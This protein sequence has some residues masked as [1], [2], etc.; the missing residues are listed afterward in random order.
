M[1]SI[2][3]RPGNPLGFR[4]AFFNNDLKAWRPGGLALEFSPVPNPKSLMPLFS[5]QLMPPT[6]DVNDS[7]Y[8]SILDQYRL[9]GKIDR[10]TDVSR[11]K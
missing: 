1:W 8:V 9:L 11:H 3:T 2:G 4:A 7:R 5:I 6:R 10:G